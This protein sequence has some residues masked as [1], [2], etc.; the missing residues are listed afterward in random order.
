MRLE[1]CYTPTQH[2][3]KFILIGLDCAAPKL[4]FDRYLDRLPNIK[5]LMRDG[6]FGPLRSTDPPITV[7]AW[8]SMTTSKDPGQLG[9]YGFRNR[10]D[11]S[12]DTL[13]IA[14]ASDIRENTIW[15][16]LSHANLA[17]L[18]VGVPQ[19]YPP[20]PLRGLLVSSFL[21]PSKQSTW[22]YPADWRERVDRAAG[23]NYIFDVEDFRGDDLEKL[24]FGIH[25]MTR[26]R[27]RAFRHFLKD[28][29]SFNMMVEIGLDRMQHRFWRYSDTT[30]P[31]YDTKSPWKDALGEYH[32]LIDREI[33]K[34]LK[35]ADENTDIMIVSDHGAKKMH[36]AIAINQFFI[37][38]GLLK[39]KTVPK[40]P[41]PLKTSM[42]D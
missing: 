26:A 27:F 20:K 9:F 24:L 18:V 4:V 1:V 12:Y 15:D 6:V 31:L 23:G 29:Y 32:E 14:T 36:G 33:G 30:H 17:S 2:M 35:Y 21:T 16:I 28:D 3:K 19:T 25:E 5:G 40:N 38:Q 22:T 34:I 10:P 37:N 42:I 13:V 7:P 41:A 39:L 8:A 11:T